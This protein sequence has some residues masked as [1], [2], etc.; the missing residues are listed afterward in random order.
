MAEEDRRNAT[1]LYNPYKFKDMVAQW[2][3]SWQDYFTE[4]FDG[5]GVVVSDDEKIIVREPEFLDGLLPILIAAPADTVADYIYWR[6]IM[7]LADEGPKEL[8]DIAFEFTGALQGTDEPPPRL[9]ANLLLPGFNSI[10]KG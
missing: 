8:V 5:T 7:A 4:I 3:I 1:E 2:P 10:S 6:S 9:V